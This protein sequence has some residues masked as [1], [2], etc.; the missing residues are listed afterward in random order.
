MDQRSGYLEVILGPMFS[1]KTSK[2]LETQKQYTFCEIP[3]IAINHVD[4]TRYGIH[5]MITHDKQNIDCFPASTIREVL[6]DHKDKL[7]SPEPLV[8]LINEGQFFPDLYDAVF[9]LVTRYNKHVYVAGLDGDYNRNRFGSMLDLIPLCDKVTKLHSLC[10]YCK[11]GTK[12][13]FS[14][15]LNSKVN[16]QKQ[17]GSDDL[18]VP[19]CRKCYDNRVGE[20]GPVIKLKKHSKLFH[21]DDD[22][23]LH[24]DEDECERRKRRK[25]LF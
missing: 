1:G 23:Y 13:L 15:R 8:V 7:E 3:V 10:V 17:I 16:D 18:Y 11:N 24:E 4:D 6:L 5:Q 19:L 2:L 21:E 25:K 9:E 22:E 20:R 12:A 14:H